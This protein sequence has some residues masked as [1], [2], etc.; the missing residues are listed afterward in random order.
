MVKR[1]DQ[2]QAN[3]AFEELTKLTPV[4]VRAL[5]REI[6]EAGGNDQWLVKKKAIYF[7]QSGPYKG[8]LV[9]VQNDDGTIPYDD[10]S[11]QIKQVDEYRERKQYAED[12]EEERRTGI[13]PR[14]ERMKKLFADAKNVT[15]AL[16]A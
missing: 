15:K 1:L 12:M 2:H 6:D 10:L 4:E 8:T 5:A 11:R 7:R 13:N 3:K 16:K 14:P 9:V